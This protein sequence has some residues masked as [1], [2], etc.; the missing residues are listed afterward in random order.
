VRHLLRRVVDEDVE[1]AKLVERTLDER[2]AVGLFAD[3]PRQLDG[4]AA[5]FL[6]AAG[7]VVAVA[8][9]LGRGPSAPSPSYDSSPWSAFGV[10]SSMV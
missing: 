3:V 7:R 1:P 10:S 9:L 8:L 4:P 5:G 2:D 6:D